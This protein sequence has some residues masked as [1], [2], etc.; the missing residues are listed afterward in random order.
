MTTILV[1][2]VNGDTGRPMVDYLLKEGFEVR[3]MVRKDD[4]RAQQL[5]VEGVEV[6]FG[7]LLNFRDVGSPRE[8]AWVPE[9][10]LMPLV[11]SGSRRADLLQMLANGLQSQSIT[12]ISIARTALSRA[13]VRCS[14]NRVVAPTMRLERCGTASRSFRVGRSYTGCVASAA[15]PPVDKVLIDRGCRIHEYLYRIEVL[16]DGAIG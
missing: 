2:A 7:D 11:Q 16:A 8:T 4:D 5:R 13:A 12:G 1:T 15:Q 9:E 3:A 10:L 14:R 6:V